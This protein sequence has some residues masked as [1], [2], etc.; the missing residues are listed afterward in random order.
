[1]GAIVERVRRSSASIKGIQGET[2]T[3]VKEMEQ[4]VHE[5]ETGAELSL[6]SGRSLENI[7]ERIND[8]TLQINQ[9]ATAAEEQTATT[10]EVASNISLM[11]GSVSQSSLGAQD[12]A[13]AAR[14]L[15]AQ[16]RQ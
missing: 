1:M 9:I 12:T 15:A 13:A 10:G 8:V 3:A 16:A 4:G 2:R 11:T 7:L 6:R 5:A 14:Q